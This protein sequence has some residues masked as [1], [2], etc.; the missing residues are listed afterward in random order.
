MRRD[1]EDPTNEGAA[2]DRK[3]SRYRPAVCIDIIK[4]SGVMCQ[5]GI[6]KMTPPLLSLVLSDVLVEKGKSTFQIFN[7]YLSRGRSDPKGTK[8]HFL[9]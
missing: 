3:V 2:E 9:T 4:R 7:I 1:T 6:E 5:D 8:S